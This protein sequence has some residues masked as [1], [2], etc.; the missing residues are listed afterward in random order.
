[1]GQTFRGQCAELCGSG[2]SIMLFEVQALSAA[3]FDAWLVEKS[4]PAPSAP[5]PSGGPAPSGQPAPSDGAADETLT[6]VAK[7]LKFDQA[8][9]TA[10]AD[11]PFSIDFK[12]EDPSIP[13]NVAIHR[14]RPLARRSSRARSSPASPKRSTSSR[15]CRPAPT[16]SSVR[17]IRP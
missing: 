4:T 8:S 17:S 13:H 6:L 2:H 15:H 12:N 10:A 7:D 16:A 14:D 5:P 1:M 3:D 9:L 11:T